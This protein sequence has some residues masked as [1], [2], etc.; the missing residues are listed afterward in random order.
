MTKQLSEKTRL[1]QA[2]QFE[3]ARAQERVG[4]GY[5]TAEERALLEQ[6]ELEFFKAKAEMEVAWLRQSQG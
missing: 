4:G 1:F 2:A 3:L 6:L 5:Q